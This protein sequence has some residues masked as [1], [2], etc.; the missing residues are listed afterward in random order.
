[1]VEIKDKSSAAL[2]DD[3]LSE[4]VLDRRGVSIGTLECYWETPGGSLLLG[5]KINEKVRVI[6]GAFAQVDDRHSCVVVSAEAARVK[7]GPA[8][9]CD[10]DVE[11]QLELAAKRHFGVD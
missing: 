1:M 3:F 10:Q 4:E 9:D 5:I 11:A 6:P 8:L 7:T 2:L